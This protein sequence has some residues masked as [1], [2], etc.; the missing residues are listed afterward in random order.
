MALIRR[1]PV[2]VAGWPVTEVIDMIR[3]RF[4]EA[5][6]R[7]TEAIQTGELMVSANDQRIRVRQEE[8]LMDGR[9]GDWLICGV[10]DDLSICPGTVFEQTYEIV[11]G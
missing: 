9:P 1:V 8:A 6:K 4:S 11:E 10:E 2:D 7:L 5:P 3:H